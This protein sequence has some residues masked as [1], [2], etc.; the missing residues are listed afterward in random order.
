MI[1]YVKP[2]MML[3]AIIGSSM[4]NS[5]LAY[6][7]GDMIFRAGI[8]SVQPNDDSDPLTLNGTELSTLGLG[9][10]RT[11]VQVDGNSQL[12]LTFTYMLN[13]HWAIDVLAATPFKHEIHAGALGVQAGEAK[14]LPPTVSLQYYPM[15]GG[16]NIQP[17]V[18]L[19]LNYTTFFSEE[20]DSEL[21]T[22]L[23]TLGA[24]GD[25]D[26][27]LDDSWGL[28]MQAGIDYKYNEHWILNGTIWYTD[29]ET[30]ADINVP[31]LGVL[32]TDV[33]IDPWVYMLSVGYLF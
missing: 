15:G 13:Q 1:K 33:T 30:S 19:G 20:V 11:E 24:T 21:N 9:L 25:A 23:A 22:T 4:Q 3:A 8:A 2:L 27:S 7:A 10:P 17:F 18:G 28:A 14:H 5:S 26:M 6:E 31:G 29:I 32:K 16:S 12:G